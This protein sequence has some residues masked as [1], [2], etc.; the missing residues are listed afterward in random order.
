MVVLFQV[1]VKLGEVPSNQTAKYPKGFDDVQLSSLALMTS[2]SKDCSINM[3]RRT[4][5]GTVQPIVKLA[6]D[7]RPHIKLVN[8]LGNVSPPLDKEKR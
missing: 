6:Q 5:V 2:S 4:K 8:E 1:S 3:G 7:L